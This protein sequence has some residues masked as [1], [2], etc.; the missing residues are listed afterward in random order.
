MERQDYANYV[1][2]KNLE[3][4]LMK[5][6]RYDADPLRLHAGWHW[7]AFFV[8]FWW[9]LYRKMYLWAVIVLVCAGIPFL[10]IIS[11]FG[12]PIIANVLYYRQARRQIASMKAV[13]PENPDV[14]IARL[15]GVNAWVVWVALGITALFLLIGL[16][17]MAV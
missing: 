5:F 12:F 10:G 13:F 14:H 7:P 16:A 17:A 2:P 1:G 3:K 6:A 8:S 9:C 11:W 15:G 4:Y